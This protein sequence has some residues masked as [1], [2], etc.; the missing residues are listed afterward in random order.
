[1]ERYIIKRVTDASAPFANAQTAEVSHYHPNGTPGVA[2]RVQAQV[3]WDDTALYV[4][5]RAY[6]RGVY[7]TRLAPNSS[8]WND[9]CL[10]FFVDLCPDERQAYINIEI[11]ALGTMLL[12]FGDDQ[13]CAMQ[14]YDPADFDV[15]PQL[16][17]CDADPYW[18]L[19]YRVPFAAMEPYF[20][21]ITP[22]A[23]MVFR[24]NFYKCGDE[25]G[26]PHFGSWNQVDPTTN[27]SFHTYAYFG[28]MVLED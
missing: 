27:A 14:P 25:T 4:R 2:P 23:G 11:N 12:G 9:S 19:T 24:G 16:H 13:T 3:T 18:Q 8:V 7:A 6:E 21:T 17:L 15:R 28:E 22:K 5:L 20:G 26:S 1:M 10:E